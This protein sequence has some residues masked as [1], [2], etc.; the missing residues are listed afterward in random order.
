MEFHVAS[1]VSQLVGVALIAT[2]LYV[3]SPTSHG[4][5][6]AL[7]LKTATYTKQA[8]HSVLT[9]P[10]S[11]IPGPWYS[12][13]TDVI[14]KYQWFIGQRPYYVHSLHQKY[15][16]IVRVSP[17]EVMVTD[18]DAIK[19]IYSTRETYRKSKFYYIFSGLPVFSL[20]STT[21]VDHH[22]KLR[23]LMASQLSESSLK[24]LI[25][26]VSS[27][28]ELAIQ[29]MKEEAKT[30]GVTDVF[31]WTL[32]M[33]TDVIG[34]LSFGESF[35]MLEQGEKNQYA[36]DLESISSVSKSRNVFPFFFQLVQRYPTA[37]PLL[38]E[39][40]K[41]AKRL[42]GYARQSLQRYQDYIDSDPATVKQTFFTKMFK[43]QEDEKI[44]FNEIVVN[45]QAFIVAGSDTTAN[46]LTYLFWT[47]GK[48]PDLRD[49]LVKEIQ[50][51]P[52]GFTDHDLRE[53]PLLNQTIEE[54]L[55]L[56][57]SV[58]AALPREVPPGGADI[59]GYWLK[60]GTSVG[61]QSYTLHR[62][63]NI[64]PEPYEFDPKR[65]ENPTKAMTEAFMP[66]G[67]GP[68]IC[69]GLHLAYIE[70]RLATVRFFQEFPNA[71]VST[72]EGMSDACMDPVAYFLMG[73]KGKQCLIEP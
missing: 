27:R 64:F 71:Q 24:S 47:V 9:N 35:K 12:K 39:M 56:Y 26:Q 33:A 28:V 36:K 34:E 20:F 44:T 42:I 52:E 46:T 5:R 73:P 11:K 6:F 49:A 72:R 67:R 17:S 61:T 57:S 65:W 45:A 13:W 29:R 4:F 40:D 48:R 10:T 53:L 30:R 60:A 32:F 62:D 22:R 15:G 18:L 50:T 70:L 7:P 19:I 66:F 58:P 38:R 37:L 59:G 1:H 51:L 41:K 3:G 25:P 14:L 55:R 54:T 2:L 23:R 31:K 63:P 43:A 69:I 68:R 16:P 21:D 8:V